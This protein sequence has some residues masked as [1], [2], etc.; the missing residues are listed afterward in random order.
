VEINGLLHAMAIILQ[1][2]QLPLSRK[3]GEHR[4]GSK[5]CREKKMFLFCRESNSDCLL[6]KPTALSL[7]RLKNPSVCLS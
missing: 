1:G 4:E 3:L 7:Q 5:P 2:I 6:V